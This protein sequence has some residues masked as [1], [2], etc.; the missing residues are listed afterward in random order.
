LHVPPALAVG[1]LPLVMRQPTY[2]FPIAVGIGT[3][4]LTM[5]FLAW[6]IIESIESR[7][8]QLAAVA[9]AVL[10]IETGWLYWSH[11]GGGAVH[12][13]TRTLERGAVVRTVTAS[14]IV[15]PA[16]IMPVGAHA[17]GLIQALFC[18][19]G[20]KV[21]AGRLCAKIDPRPYQLAVD[22]EK[23]YLAE[24]EARLE[25]DKADLVHAKKIFERN[26]RLAR[27]RGISRMAFHGSRTTYARA[28]ARMTQDEGSITERQ[29]ALHAAETGLGNTD[30]VS[31]VDG[32]VA[33]RNV[34]IGKAVAADSKTPL[35]VIATDLAVIRVDSNLDE[36]DI[37]GAKLGDE[38]TFTVGSLPDHLFAGKVTRISQL[39]RTIKKAATYDVV[40][41]VPNPDLSLKPGMTATVTIVTDR[42]DGV[43][44]TPDLALRYSP[45]GRTA[46]TGTGAKAPPK[47]ASRLWVLRD[48]KPTAIVVELGL[49]DGA[50]TEIVKGDLRPDDDVIIG[51]GTIPGVMPHG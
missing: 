29:A 2:T 10:C 38:A 47:S 33:L 19:N 16:I 26:R 17:S 44:R 24:A 35:F 51:S 39:P 36:K 13:V 42:R 28:Q 7:G 50:Y 37:D 31:P 4:L 25:K 12:Y 48:G 9:F 23:A 20:A 3:L 46:S 32:T 45:A 40:I 15:N 22:Q 8:Q 43:L 21:K 6:R 27:R 1:L 49:D 5:F 41:S 18:D 34:D 30:I 11:Y 14:G